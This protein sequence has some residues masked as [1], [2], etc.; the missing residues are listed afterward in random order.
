MR[1]SKKARPSYSS[2]PALNPLPTMRPRWLAIIG[3]LAGDTRENKVEI[4]GIAPFATA[5]DAPSDPV[6]CPELA[7]R[8]GGESYA[9]EEAA[10]CRSEKRTA[11]PQMPW[12]R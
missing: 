8:T 5:A 4:F 2:S 11:C 6:G 7:E 9:G 12:Q 1:H 3:N 10:E